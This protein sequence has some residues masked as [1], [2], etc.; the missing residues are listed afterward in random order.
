MKKLIVGILLTSLLTV[1]KAYADFE[2]IE[3]TLG[4]VEDIQKKAQN[5]Q[6]KLKKIEA[7]INALRQ[8]DFGPLEELVSGITNEVKVDVKMLNPLSE[9]AGD[10]QGMEDAFEENLIPQYTDENQDETYLAYQETINATYRENLARL[11]AYAL[12]LRT[13]MEKTRQENSSD[14][15]PANADDSREILQK[16]ATKEATEN[17]RRMAHIWDMQSSILELYIFEISKNLSNSVDEEETGEN[18]I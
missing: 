6:E 12:T 9:K 10:N 14:D 2:F 8:G 18:G 15:E 7:Q 1:T 3:T 16:H 5:V 11:Y 17:A 4:K 13:N